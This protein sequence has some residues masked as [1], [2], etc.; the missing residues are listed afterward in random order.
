MNM[1]SI[2]EIINRC[3]TGNKMDT[4]KWDMGVFK[5]CSELVKQY[6]ITYDP[7][8]VVPS[9]DSLAD[10]VFKAGFDLFLDLGF[11][12]E[13]EKRQVTFSEEEI[14]EAMNSRPSQATV[15]AGKDAVTLF[16]RNIEDPRKPISGGCMWATR[17]EAMAIPAIMSSAQEPL[18]HYLE[19]PDY[20]TT[21]YGIK[22]MLQSPFNIQVWRQI[23]AWTLEAARRV[24]RPGLALYESKAEDWYNKIHY[25]RPTDF[26]CAGGWGTFELKATYDSLCKAAYVSGLPFSVALKKCSGG[27][28]IGGFAGGPEG[29]VVSAIACSHLSSI[30]DGGILANFVFHSRTKSISGND[31]MWANNVVGQALAK[32]TNAMF[33]HGGGTGSGPGTE[34]CFFEIAAMCIGAV[35]GGI[36]SWLGCRR[37]AVPIEDLGTGLECR[38]GAEVANA[39]SGMKRKVANDIVKELLKKYED[40]L[41]NPPI[42]KQFQE[43]YDPVKIKPR[44]SYLDL[45]KKAKKKL[46]GLGLRFES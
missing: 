10:D 5:K 18:I 6:G 11:Y 43:C 23:N 30:F 14:R 16:H 26:W 40:K 36:S 44:K 31:T 2:W 37:Y 46:E 38:F 34:M 35:V 13:P 4:K 19:T 9:D 45:Y 24:G 28:I 39:A 1:V 27:S 17:S 32:N 20:L 41:K 42:G 15:G 21:L 33:T 12:Y 8:S 7:E 3:F 22:P 25:L 29:A